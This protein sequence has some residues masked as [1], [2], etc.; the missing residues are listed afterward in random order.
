M[1][2]S[3]KEDPKS[4]VPLTVAELA[5]AAWHGPFLEQGPR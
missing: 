2:M 4:I 3:R 1:S 5:E